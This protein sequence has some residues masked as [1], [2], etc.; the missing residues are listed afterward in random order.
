MVAQGA[1]SNMDCLVVSSLPPSVLAFA[2]HASSHGFRGIFEQ[3]FRDITMF[4]IT[5]TNNM[6]FPFTDDF[7]LPTSVLAFACHAS[8]QRFL[9]ISEQGF[10]DITMFAITITILN[11]CSSC[12]PPRSQ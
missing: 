9:G 8:P 12:V 1:N 4:A 10:R 6:D 3:R 11:V 7:S 5:T 2:C